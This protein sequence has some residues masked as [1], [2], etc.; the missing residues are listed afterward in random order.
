MNCIKNIF[1]LCFFILLYGLEAA[2]LNL[3]VFSKN[4]A[5]QVHSFLESFFL[6]TTGCQRVSVIYRAETKEHNDGYKIV[7]NAFP[8]VDFIKQKSTSDFKELTLKAIAFDQE[9]YVIFAVDDII[10]T[11]KVDFDEVIQFLQIHDTEGFYLRMGEHITECYS[12]NRYTGIPPLEEVAPGILSWHFKEGKGDWGYPHTVDMTVYRKKDLKKIFLALPFNNP[13]TL[14]GNW[15]CVA[16]KSPVGLCYKHA[17][18]VNCPLNIVQT[19]CKNR[20]SNECTPDELLELFLAGYVMD[21]TPLQNIINN[22][23]HMDYKP[24]FIRSQG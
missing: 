19:A 18:L 2:S 9:E 20:H 13:N 7:K 10:V 8:Q 5:H 21:I 16:P 11:R 22:A 15:A 23:P 24:T 3:V 17:A 12:E 1:I 4:R 6:N 14:E